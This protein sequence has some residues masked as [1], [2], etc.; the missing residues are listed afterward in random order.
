MAATR[1]LLAG[2]P[3]R[4]IVGGG[5]S[6]LSTATATATAATAS[7]TQQ[8]RPPHT[9]TPAPGSS[10]CASA[11]APGFPAHAATKATLR[12]LAGKSLLRVDDYTP[13]QLQAILNFSHD[14]KA[15]H[16]AEYFT[17]PAARA[18]LGKSIAMI[19]QKRSTRT[20]V[21]TETGANLLGMQ[22]LF[23]GSEDVQLGVNESLRDTAIVLARYNSLILARVFGH[24]TVA[25]LSKY[26]TV[27]VINALSNSHHPLQSLADVMTLQER[28]GTNLKNLTVSWVGDGNN[29]LSDLMLACVMSG[30]K[31]RIATPPRDHEPSVEVVQAA[32][33]IAETLGDSPTS[34]VELFHDPTQALRGADVVVTDTW[35]SMGQESQKAQRL[36]TFA[37]YKITRDLVER[38]GAKPGWVF[39]HCLPRHPEEVDDDV[40]YSP[41]SIVFDEA[42]NRMY[43]VMAVMLTMLGKV[44]V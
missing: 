23:L 13:A 33:R 8:K 27:P 7:Q 2:L 28:F 10:A 30:A 26:S 5:L 4:P 12:Q 41:N 40:F 24:D 25:T 37:P 17:T 42:E 22:S 31:V 14:L 1:S 19:F 3:R 44:D 20:R 15:K 38:S 34:A 16:K 35:V 43:T 39:L 18:L 32:R 11:K 6:S 9:T 21:S 36:K 29:V